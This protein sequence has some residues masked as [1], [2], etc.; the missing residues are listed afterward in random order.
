MKTTWILCAALLLGGMSHSHAQA[1][2]VGRV[3][4]EVL[5]KISVKGGTTAA[6]ELAEFGGEAAV[7][8]VLQQAEKEGGEQ[9][10]SLIS[11]Q[12]AEHGIVALQAM[13]GA[14]KMVAQAVE[15]LP[16]ELAENGLRAVARQPA[17]MQQVLREA[18]QEGLEA[19]ARHPGVGMQVA[20][21]LG[22]EGAETAAKVST[23]AATVLARHADDLAKLGA[24]ERSGLLALMK[25]AP[26]K[27]LKFLGRHPVGTLTAAVVASFLLN[28]DVYLG[29]ADAPGFIERVFG[30]PL[31]AVGAVFAGLLAI[32][33]CMK[34]VFAWRRM[35]QRAAVR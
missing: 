32:W 21:K 3:A 30:E 4:V 17:A 12:T 7:K 27:V 35:K 1:G 22:R 34:L 11:R 31:R 10:L 29:S 24:K 25:S 19:A 28:P 6:R 18:G 5:E 8:E 20:Q 23:E 2:A 9:L 13:K 33:G 16:A 14:P 15:K 26:E